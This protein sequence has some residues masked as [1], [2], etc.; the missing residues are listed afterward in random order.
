MSHHTWINGLS[1]T[2]FNGYVPTPADFAALD[3]AL[4]QLVNGDGGGVWSPAAPVIIGGAGMWLTSS[5]FLTQGATVVGNISFGDSDYFLFQSHVSNSRTLVQSFLSLSPQSG[6]LEGGTTQLGA[7]GLLPL[8]VVSAATLASVVLS[9]AVGSSH[10]GIPANM[11]RFRVC[12]VSAAGVVTPLATGGVDVNGFLPLATPASGSA[13]YDGGATQTATYTCTTSNVID[14]A[15]GY[16]L[17]VVDESGA[18]AVPGNA[19]V[20]ASLNFVSIADNRPW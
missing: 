17:E 5:S 20:Q 19:Y 18:N 1:G 14:L 16:F 2:W 4:E 11:A 10:G 6:W 9:F 7:R 13:W 12:A 15:H 8:R 3:Q